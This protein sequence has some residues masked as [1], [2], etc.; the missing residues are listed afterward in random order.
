MIK[1]LGTKVLQIQSQ[2]SIFIHDQQRH[3]AEE[4]AFKLQIVC[5]KLTPST[6][7]QKLESKVMP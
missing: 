3:N 6:A 2:R 7:Q 4:R 5:I 1:I